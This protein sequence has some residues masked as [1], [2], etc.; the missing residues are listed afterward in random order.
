MEGKLII[1]APMQRLHLG[2]KLRHGDKPTAFIKSMNRPTPLELDI[3]ELFGD[4]D[5]ESG[6]FAQSLEGME[7]YALILLYWDVVED[8]TLYHALLLAKD[9]ESKEYR[10][11]GKAS[12]FS[13]HLG[14]K[15]EEQAKD[16]RPIVTLV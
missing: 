7:V 11:K 3:D 4:C 12:F 5:K 15:P 1:Q 8:Y 9:L 16:E 2:E 13:P 14:W 10:R 6:R